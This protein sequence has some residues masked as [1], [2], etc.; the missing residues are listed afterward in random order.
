[1]ADAPPLTKA[2]IW[3]LIHEQR[4]KTTTMLATLTP[5]QW[6]TQSL[7]ADWTVRDV[8]AHCI[9]TQLMTP[10]RFFSL[11]ASSGFR[12]NAMQ[13]RRVAL[14]RTEPVSDLLEQFRDSAARNSGP[15]P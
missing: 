4:D 13:A 10:G 2:D 6:E 15:S 14:H 3:R 1:M 5:E 7:C 11:F 8:A 12:F 9:E